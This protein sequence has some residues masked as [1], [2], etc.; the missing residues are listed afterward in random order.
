M[1]SVPGRPD[2]IR[3][4]QRLVSYPV[5]RER[6]RLDPVGTAFAEG[7]PGLA[8]EI[9]DGGLEALEERE[10]RSSL[11]GL[12]TSLAI[13]GAVAFGAVHELLGADAASAAVPR[14]HRAEFASPALPADLEAS[15]GDD[16]DEE[17][18]DPG[19]DIDEDGED[20][21][22]GDDGEDGDSEEDDDSDEE[23]D[24]P[25]EDIDEDGEDR[26][27]DDDGEDGDSEEDED[28]DEEDDGSDEED[29]GSD[30]E[31]GG[32]DEAPDADDDGEEP[33]VGGSDS[34][35]PNDA[36][37]RY[38]GRGAS[39]GP[40]KYPGD[41]A[42]RAQ[43]AAWM[44][45]APHDRG[46]P[47]ELPVMASLV[48]SG[49][50]N[51]SYGDADSVGFFQMRASI[52]DQ[53]E[54]AGYAGRPELQLEWFL[55]HAEA[56]KQ[57]RVA[58]GLPVDD[59]ARYGEWIADVERPAAQFRG[60]YQLRL[61]DARDLLAAFE[62]PEAAPAAGERAAAALAFARSMMGTPYKWGGETPREGFDCSGLVQWAYAK[63]GITLPRVTDQQFAARGGVAVK[64]GDL[65]PGDLVFFR[66]ATGYVHHVGISLGGDRFVDAPHTGAEV[67][68]DSLEDAYWSKEFAGGRR[69][70]QVLGRDR[71]DARVLPVVTR[72]R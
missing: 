28:S 36:L 27:D 22:D 13:E 34:D 23:D 40:A 64:R 51:L 14:H 50:Q 8:L 43:L 39:G 19:E 56:V 11:A 55:D 61:D 46:L 31:E 45:R 32:E 1:A 37:E 42:P 2:E 65:V 5:L 53:G 72:R 52:W 41:D 68:I 47:P 60:R 21:P 70:D 38:V 18:D 16:E 10:S 71:G 12:F 49:V 17:D 63:A 59:P 15:G 35:D 26:P 20:S 57:Q 3:F 48:E 24:D 25:G 6:Y 33:N 58:R 69:F 4:L 29:D 67:R 44:A 7:L 54:Y 30:D 9:E 62:P 66:D